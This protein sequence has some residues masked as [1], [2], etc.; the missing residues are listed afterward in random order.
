MQIK[1]LITFKY[2]IDQEIAPLY[3]L[4]I[5]NSFCSSCSVNVAEII[6][7]FAFSCSKKAYFKN[8]LVIPSR[9]THLNLFLFLLLPLHYCMSL[10][11]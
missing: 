7:G 9:L 1:G 2:S 10:L 11:Y 4:R 6:T 8:V 3:F 5:S